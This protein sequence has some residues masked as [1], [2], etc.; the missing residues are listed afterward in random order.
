MAPRQLPPAR[1][2]C[3]TS[4][5]SPWWAR[6]SVSIGRTFDST[7]CEDRLQ[8]ERPWPARMDRTA[9]CPTTAIRSRTAISGCVYLP[10]PAIDTRSTGARAPAARPACPGEE[11]R[12]DATLPRC[13]GG[14]SVG[15]SL[16]L[17]FRYVLSA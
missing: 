10:A 5:S 11:P 16:P 1:S 9:R 7:V 14:S 6:R 17:H 3:G 15:P 13:G 12:A 2:S 4:T 8:Q